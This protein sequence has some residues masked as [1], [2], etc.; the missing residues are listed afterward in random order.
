MRGMPCRG[1]VASQEHGRRGRH[2]PV[3]AE[4]HQLCTH[5]CTH[6]RALV[7]PVHRL[8]ESPSLAPHPCHSICVTLS[9]S[10]TLQ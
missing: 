1:P 10:T 5:R 4:P 6:S 9:P 2:V 3:E 7:F 8:L